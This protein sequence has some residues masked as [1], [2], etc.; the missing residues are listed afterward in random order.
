MNEQYIMS[1]CLSHGENALALIDRIWMRHLFHC[2]RRMCKQKMYFGIC[3]VDEPTWMSQPGPSLTPASI[4][5]TTPASY[6]SC[7][8]SS[9]L[10]HHSHDT[11][12]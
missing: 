7:C 9:A 12:P 10:E 3:K 2:H 1:T 11:L 6:S 4:V 5:L 8:N